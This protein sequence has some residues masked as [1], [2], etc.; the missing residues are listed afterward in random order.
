ML[1]RKN[2]DVVSSAGSDGICVQ[3]KP[4]LAMS[5]LQCTK[6]VQY[7]FMHFLSAS[8][9]LCDTGNGS[10]P[11]PAAAKPAGQANGRPPASQQWQSPQ[12]SPGPP[13]NKPMP[14]DMPAT[15]ETIKMSSEFKVQPCTKA[16]LIHWHSLLAWHVVVLHA[17]CTVCNCLASSRESAGSDD[18]RADL[19]GSHKMVH[20]MVC[21]N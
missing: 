2:I 6:A 1:F 10:V 18:L 3:P 14:Q 19:Y 12:T 5:I 9:R 20:Q 8:E 7:R 21:L 11:A 15:P 4:V 17:C 16:L 13:P